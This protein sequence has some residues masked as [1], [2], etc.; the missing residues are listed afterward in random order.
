M[1][2]NL[3]TEDAFAFGIDLESQLA[4]VEF[5]DRQVILRSLDHDFQSRPLSVLS[6][7]RAAFCSEDGFEQFHI[8]A[9]VCRQVQAVRQPHVFDG[10]E[11]LE[12]SG[13]DN[14]AR[15]GPR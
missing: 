3:D 10:E 13:L 11:L 12:R 1:K 15:I 5:K 7:V 9:G 2:N 4:E 8:Q 6:P 14:V